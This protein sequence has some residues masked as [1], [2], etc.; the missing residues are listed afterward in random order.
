[1]RIYKAKKLALLK[2]LVRELRKELREK[3]PKYRQGICN[4]TRHLLTKHY[5]FY[6]Y[7]YLSEFTMQLG[8]DLPSTR[9]ED[10][11][12]WPRTDKG[13]AQRIQFIK[14]IIKKLN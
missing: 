3:N 4:K 1:M 2:E 7:S 12:C 6:S 10:F 8:I 14:D 9:R 5:G 11:Y 13:Y